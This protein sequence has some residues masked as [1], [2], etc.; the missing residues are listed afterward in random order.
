M[1]YNTSEL[2]KIGSNPNFRCISRTKIF[3][4]DIKMDEFKKLGLS[5]E[6]LVSLKKKG[7]EKPT[8]IQLKAIPL[9]LKG[10]KDVVGQSQTGTGKTASFALPI[11]EKLRGGSKKPKALILTP[12]RELALQVT[13]EIGSLQPKNKLKLLAVYGGSSM[14][15][16]IKHLKY[17]IDVVVGTPGRIKDLINRGKLDV[18]NIRY[19][20][21][22]EADEMLNMG[23]IDDIEDILGD[24]NQ[25]KSMLL[26]SATMPKQ[27]LRIA[28]RFMKDYEFIAVK[29]EQITIDLTE[30]FYYSVKGKDRFECLKRVIDMS[31]DFYGIVFCKTRA[32]TDTLAHKLIEANY[33]AGAIHGDITQGQREKI[34]LQ[35]RKKRI[36]ILV[37]T[38]VAARGID[39]NDLTHVINNSLPQSAESYV[40]RIGR[41]GRAGKKGTAI[42]FVIPSER[43]KLRAVEKIIK[44]QLQERDVP[45][46]KEVISSKLERM[47][48]TIEKMLTSKN[49]AKFEEIAGHL[50][51]T[52]KPK[53]IIA[54]LLSH[55]FEKEVNSN[56]Y[57]EMG[58]GGDRS[59][60][61][62]GRRSRD[63]GFSGGR[64]RP[65]REDRNRG[66]SRGGR[67]GRG[68]RPRSRDS[69][70]SGR[71]NRDER[72]RRSGNASN[73]S[74]KRSNSDG[75]SKRNRKK[76][77]N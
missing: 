49:A 2:I 38:D 1:F 36:N 23:F 77:N 53:E 33:S 58:K 26:F 41:T 50:L 6:T 4:I 61:R 18:K 10:E 46:I 52:H 13:K 7:F 9:L 14:N 55:T 22:D 63:R 15:E 43:G 28:K 73:R 56:N 20:V 32:G 34:L 59:S 71:R 72:P 70:R 60:R 44:Q 54:S 24:T 16:Q 27:I 35:F 57:Q 25:D 19:A 30:Q 11:I 42:T 76:R 12:T 39:V 67:G 64:N 47:E 40:H 31:P 17:G 74:F 48:K 75:G 65:R 37:A 45:S 5:D 29:K 62:D 51:K 3:E 21:L 66:G 8:E 69:E 68:D